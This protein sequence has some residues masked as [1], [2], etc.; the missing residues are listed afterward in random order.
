MWSSLKEKDCSSVKHDPTQ[1]LSSTHWLRFVLRK[2]SSWR[3]ER[4]YTGKYTN[5]WG[6]RESYLTPNLQHGRQ[7]PSNLLAKKSADHPSEQS[8]KYEETRRS[9]CEE[10][11]RGNVDYRIQGIL[12]STVQKEDCDRKEIVKRL[13]QQFEN[14]PKPMEPD[15]DHLC[16]S[17]CITKHMKCWRKFSTTKNGG[18]KNILDR[19]NNDD[20][21]RKSSSDIGWTEEQ[22]IQY[23]EIASEDH[24]YVAT[25]QERNRNEKSWELSLNAECSQGPLNQRSVFNEAKLTC[26]RLYHEYTAITGS[27]NKLIPPDKGLINSWNVLKKTIIDVKLLQDG[28]TILLPRR[29]HLRHHDGNQAATCGQLAAGIRGNLL[30]GLNSDFSLV[31]VMSFRLP[32]I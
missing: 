21:Y 27:G 12:H 28:D 10:T 1:S 19:W 32:E 26:K 11:C 31:P 29:S 25:Q 6:Y 18:Y 22:I 7:D 30:P 23:D 24:S 4:I 9:R 3:L 17:V 2:R 15:M 8:A 13:I 20:K 14:H 5:P 16:D